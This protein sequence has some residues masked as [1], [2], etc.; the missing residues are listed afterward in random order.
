M[1]VHG[2]VSKD[3]YDLSTSQMHRPKPRFFRARRR[4][5]LSSINLGFTRIT[6]PFDGRLS[7]SL[8]F[9]GTLISAGTNINTRVQLRPIY[10]TFSLSEGDIPL[11]K[12]TKA[13]GPVTATITLSEDPKDRYEGRQTFL[14]NVVD[15]ST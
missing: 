15:R 14:D 4:E 2:N 10:A 12:A 6:A 5:E 9:P 7:H 11:V 1:V 8:V 3:G 13:K